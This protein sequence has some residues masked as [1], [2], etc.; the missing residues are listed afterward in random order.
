MEAKKA[1]LAASTALEARVPQCLLDAEPEAGRVAEPM[2][3]CCLVTVEC[4]TGAL[5]RST[6]LNKGNWYR[7]VLCMEFESENS[8]PAQASGTWVCG[9]HGSML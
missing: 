5:A 7:T 1:N 6:M 4:R 3:T 2:S 8:V 9:L